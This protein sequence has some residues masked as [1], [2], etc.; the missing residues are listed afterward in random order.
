MENL[1]GPFTSSSLHMVTLLMFKLKCLQAPGT[2]SKCP[3]LME[4]EEG[5]TEV[6]WGLWER[7]GQ[8]PSP[9][10][11]VASNF[12]SLV[13]TSLEVPVTMGDHCS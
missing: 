9:E 5:C 12:S 4:C 13:F 1:Q 3:R 11:S 6:K 8:I 7:R 2:T 10:K